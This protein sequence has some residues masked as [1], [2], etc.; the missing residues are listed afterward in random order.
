MPRI[1]LRFKQ[2]VID[3]A[4]KGT[5]DNEAREKAVE[6]CHEWAE[7]IWRHA[8]GGDEGQSAIEQAIAATAVARRFIPIPALVHD[9]DAFS[10]R[11]AGEHYWV[12]LPSERYLPASPVE[13]DTSKHPELCDG[14]LAARRE[15]D[16][17]LLRE[18]EALSAVSAALFAATT[19]EEFLA[20]FPEY[21]GV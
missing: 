4:K 5:V 18:D 8:I 13:L 14:F 11:I 21:E 2:R 9:G 12:T 16:S 19:E 17:V 3:K 7:R 6:A 1:T 15:L 10:V 20:N